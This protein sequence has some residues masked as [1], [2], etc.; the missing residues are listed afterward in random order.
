M[1]FGFPAVTRL[2]WISCGHSTCHRN[3]FRHLVPLHHTPPAPR[4]HA[5]VYLIH[6]GAETTSCRT[7]V[8]VFDMHCIRHRQSLRH[9]R[10]VS[11]ID[12]QSG[13]PDMAILMGVNRLRPPPGF[14]WKHVEVYRQVSGTRSTSHGV[15]SVI[16]T[17]SYRCPCIF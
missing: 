6:V 10:N 16:C 9:W 3:G 12:I 4:R 8:G 13:L 5:S 17:L 11:V 7:D 2:S 1:P 14:P 15:F